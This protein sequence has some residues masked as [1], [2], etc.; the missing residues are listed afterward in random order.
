MTYDEAIKQLET[1]ITSLETDEALS[2]EAYKAKAQEAQSLIAFCQTQLTTLEQDL[3]T[4]L[5]PDTQ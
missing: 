1:I 5:P 2:M 3:Q 4:L